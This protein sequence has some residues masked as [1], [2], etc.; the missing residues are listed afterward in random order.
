MAVARSILERPAQFQWDADS[1]A[2]KSDN[3]RCTCEAQIAGFYLDSHISPATMR[4]R[5]VGNVA[6]GTNVDQGAAA[7]NGYGIPA[8][9][10]W[11][12][13]NAVRALLDAGIPVD[14]GVI[15]GQIPKG[16]KQDLGFF[17]Y[18][19]VLACARASVNGVPGIWVRDPDR[20][21]HLDKAFWPDSVWVPAFVSPSSDKQSGCVVHPKVAKKIPAVVVAPPTPPADPS[22]Y[23]HTVETVTPGDVLRGRA[24]P[25]ATAT[26]L[27]ALP[28]KTRIK[29]TRLMTHG[30]A[31]TVAGRVRED[32]LCYVADGRNVWVARAYTKLIS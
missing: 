25:N 10:G 3:C 13:P 12:S 21:D 6:G 7:L 29:T 4:V 22:P 16:Y 30:G 20:W 19:S 23:V 17:G 15:Y 9:G 11:K 18:H 28:D 1:G 5:M 31:Y 26:V 32:W 24:Q 27:N 14:I 8:F 2:Y